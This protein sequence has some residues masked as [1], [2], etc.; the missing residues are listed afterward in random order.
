MKF[1][2]KKLEL[3]LLLV[4]GLFIILLPVYARTGSYPLVIVDG[5]SMYP[6]LQNGDVVY[7]HAAT[8][9]ANIPNGTIIVFV[10]GDTGIS[11]LD[12]MVRP[13]V[14]HRI[15]GQI[16]Q[17]DGQVCY[18]TKGDNN[19][20]NDPFLTRSDHVLGVGGLSIPK[21][22][23]FVLFLKSPQ[24][25][26]ATI[27]IIC[28][29]YLSIYDIKRRK[30]K[31]KDKLLGALAKK[32]LNGYLSEEQFKKLEL[33][34]KYS[35]EIETSSLRDRSVFALVDWFKN[36]TNETDWKMRMVACPKCFHI[37]VGLEGHEDSVTICSNCND[38]KT[39]NT[40][41]VLNEKNL[42]RL[43]LASIDEALSVLGSEA[44]ASLFHILENQFFLKKDEIPKRIDEF[45]V[46]MQK[47]F[48]NGSANIDLLLVNT[49]KKNLF[50]TCRV[51][52][53]S[54]PF[55]EFVKL[56]RNNIDKMDNEEEI[57]KMLPGNVVDVP[58]VLCK[59]KQD[60][61]IV[62]D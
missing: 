6:T 59:E 61:K 37:A 58:C 13:V 56:I 32:V 12:G 28:L 44:K 8:N 2:K 47:I 21:I 7:Y 42:N 23:L 3:L 50:L 48:G 55:Q 20:V 46:A 43:L 9:N 49:F 19:N 16:T 33:A 36:G 14:I 60:E 57:S 53:K 52:P 29:S 11:M 4:V 27:G 51:D 18:S 39:W 35:D 45:S 10:Q 31:N 17:S 38:V 5:N 40:T 62:E 22:G 1:T 26:I 34:V 24:G 41:L 15:V 25:L 54:F 30:D